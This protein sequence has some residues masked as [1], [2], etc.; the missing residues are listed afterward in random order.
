MTPGKV[1]LG[2]GF[3]GRS[4]TLFNPTCRT[5]GC[6][7]SGGGNAGSCSKAIGIL[8]YAEID[9]LITDSNL[10]PTFDKDAAVNY[11]SWNSD[12]WVPYDDVVTFQIKKQYAS[13]LCLGGAMIWAIDQGK[14][15][16]NDDYSGYGATT[17]NFVPT[18]SRK[19]TVQ[20]QEEVE[21]L[22]VSYI[23]FCGQTCNSGYTMVSQM[24]GQ[25]GLIQFD[26]KC[27]KNTFQSLCCPSHTIMGRCDW[28]GWKLK[29]QIT[30]TTLC[31]LVS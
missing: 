9:R 29:T 10:R 20:A 6:L 2:L 26:T 7:F 28:Y 3:S 23:S 30:I 25:V 5:P 14:G 24:S 31:R 27:A 12:Q 15:K 8:A 21:D 13:G 1:V 17:G 19:Q 11:I 4:F 16:T 18:V 22:S